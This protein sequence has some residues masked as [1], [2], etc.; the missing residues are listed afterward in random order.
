MKTHLIWI[1]LMLTVATTPAHAINA[2]YRAQLERSGCT[3]MNA[4]DGS[5]DIHK[6]KAQNAAQHTTAAVHAPLREATFTS[7][8]VN[9]TI[10][11]GFLDATINGKKA[12]VKRL[13]THFYEIHGNGFVISLSLDENGITAASWNKTTGRNH[14]ILQVSQK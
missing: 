9:A 6:T 5:C 3:E 12:I 8:A 11:N 10:S 7:D 4:N 13:N 14:G 2:H 1:A